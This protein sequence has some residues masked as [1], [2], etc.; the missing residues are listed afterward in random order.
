VFVYGPRPVYH[1][2][3][4]D[5]R[6][7]EVREDHLPERKVDR[8]GSVA[9]GIR[10]GSYLSGYE[11]G[12]SYGDLGLGLV[13]RWRPD[14]AV[15]IELSIAHHNETFNM[16]TER[17]QTLVQGSAML[18]ARPWSRMQPYVLGGMSVNERGLDDAFFDGRGRAA[19]VNTKDTLIGPHAGVGIEFAVGQKVA[20]DLDVRYVGWLNEQTAAAPG[21]LTT[22]ATFM[23]H[24]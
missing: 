12:S 1:A 2:Q 17:S 21:A 20:L 4:I 10:S 6:Q 22:S 15:G 14:E 3:Y 19:V 11:G 7:V 8:Q 5:N 18:F 23:V 13:G 24:F 16:A 9:L